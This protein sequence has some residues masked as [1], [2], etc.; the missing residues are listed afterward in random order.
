M[1]YR[2]LLH[3]PTDIKALSQPAL[4]GEM[5]VCMS[6]YDRA[7]AYDPH[8]DAYTCW[9]ANGDGTGCVRWLEDGSIVVF[10]CEGPGVIWS[11][12]SALPKQGPIRVFLVGEK[13]SKIDMPFID[14]FESNPGEIPPINLS[15]LS[16]HLFR[17]RNSYI[18]IPFHESCRIELA[19]DWGAFYHFTYTSIA[20][21]TIMPAYSERMSVDGMIA[22]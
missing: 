12:W 15:E 5:S 16:L 6:S 14:W 21:G 2:K 17:G 18:P 4:A 11:T 3:K 9:S 20:E 10:E 22:L 7:S 19:L 13:T 1:H 8:T